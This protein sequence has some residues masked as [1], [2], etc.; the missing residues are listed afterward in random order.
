MPAELKTGFKAMMHACKYQEIIII[1][2]LRTKRCASERFVLGCNLQAVM[3]FD[4]KANSEEMI[5]IIMI[6]VGKEFAGR[7]WQ[8]ASPSHISNSNSNSGSRV[9]GDC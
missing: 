8:F 4:I 5:E 1:I 2:Y 6:R 3:A 7:R 9:N